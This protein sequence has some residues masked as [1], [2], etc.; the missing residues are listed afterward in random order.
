[1]IDGQTA[2]RIPCAIAITRDPNA[3]PTFRCD[4]NR[5]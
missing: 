4:F 5:S 3:F 2:R 1:V